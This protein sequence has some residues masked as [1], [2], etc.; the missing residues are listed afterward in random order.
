M[1]ISVVMPALEMAQETGKLVAW[2]KKEGEQVTKGEPLLEIETDKAVVEIEAPADGILAGITA[3]SGAEIP[4]GQTI[5]W[6]LKPGEQIP[7]QSEP[8][9]PSARTV[10][11]PGRSAPAA[12]A[13]VAPARSTTV[14]P[15]VSPKARRLAKELSVDL[16]SI[17]GSGPG[18]TITFEDVET[19]ARA[20]KGAGSAPQE[21][22]PLSQI[23]RLMAERTAQSWT[24]VPHFFLVREVDCERLL[25]MNRQRSPEIERERGVK[26]TITDF[27]IA[28]VSRTLA[29][30]RSLNA[31]WTGTGIHP[32]PDINISLAIA[33]K[34]GVVGAVIHKADSLGLSAIAVLRRELAERARSNRL[35]PADLAGGTFTISNLGMYQV[36]SFTAI[37][38][39]PQACILALGS[40]ADRVVARDGKP[41]VRPTMTM[42]LST[43][44]R[45]ADGARAAEF[46]RDLVGD[47]QDPDTALST[48]SASA[49]TINY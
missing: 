9:A 24:T 44:H 32:N 31:S 19:A 8:P 16:G 3:E 45:V 28:I 10:S 27:L 18:G 40:I 37:I 47:M 26:P 11:S 38:A 13:T 17:S 42:T 41:A 29:R 33:V 14:A 15:Q 6:L 39:S 2:K 4:V 20:M 35:R 43:D 21:P 34:D 1:A 23:A 36:D 7:T 5:A 48:R 49:P 22:P 46:M 12:T 25:Q 30:H